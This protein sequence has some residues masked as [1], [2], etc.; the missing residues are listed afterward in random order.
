MNF[1]LTIKKFLLYS[2]VTII[3]IM[4]YWENYSYVYHLKYYHNHNIK[5]YINFTKTDIDFSFE[6]LFYTLIYTFADI[7]G[8]L[9]SILDRTVHIRELNLLSTSIKNF[10]HPVSED[11][12]TIGTLIICIGYALLYILDRIYKKINN[13]IEQENNN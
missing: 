6:I 4:G 3:I 2:F 10:L 1:E 9:I 7:I 12:L 5:E 8:F 11:E 13:N